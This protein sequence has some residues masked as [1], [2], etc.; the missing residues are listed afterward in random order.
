MFSTRSVGLLIDTVVCL[1][2]AKWETVSGRFGGYFK[3]NGD[4][5]RAV[6][7][8]INEM[9]RRDCPTSTIV[10]T[11]FDRNNKVSQHVYDQSAPRA[12]AERQVAEAKK[13][14]TSTA[15]AKGKPL[16]ESQ[17]WSEKPATPPRL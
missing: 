16:P 10:S 5:S 13:K 15:D 3:F 12:Y 1:T 6:W 11:L 14:I 17:W 4:R 8:I 7:W 2:L 9:L